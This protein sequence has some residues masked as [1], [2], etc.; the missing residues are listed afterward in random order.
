MAQV[1]VGDQSVSAR[2][3][4]APAGGFVLTTLQQG[5]GLV[6]GEHSVA[7]WPPAAPDDAKTTQ[8]PRLVECR[9]FAT[10]GLK[11]PMTPQN[12]EL[13]ITINCNGG[14]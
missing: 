14:K 8:P 1:T 13:T 3:M 9:D 4:V 11:T 7:V 10:S 2:G 6:T 5:G 12:S